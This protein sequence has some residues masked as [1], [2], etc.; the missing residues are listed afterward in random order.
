MSRE[1]F[2]GLG[3]L[4][5]LAVRFYQNRATLKMGTRCPQ[6][7]LGQDVPAT[8]RALSQRPISAFQIFSISAFTL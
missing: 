8:V 5:P 4:V 1:T 3:I 2:L 7:G 6:D